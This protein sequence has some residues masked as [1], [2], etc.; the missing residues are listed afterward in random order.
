MVKSNAETV[1]Q[2]LEELPDNQKAVAEE[3]REFIL[4]HL[5]D[6]YQEAMNWGAIT[7]QV[8]LERYPDT[9]NK[10]PLS[11]ITLAAQKNHF[12]LY[13]MGVY[14]NPALKKKLAKGYEKTGKKLDMG[15]SC[16]RFK[17][18]EELPLDTLAEVISSLTPDQFIQSYEESRNRSRQ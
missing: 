8:P 16:L 14:Q 13:L 5:P 10:M 11:Y 15:K 3:V 7:Y 17:S 12:A 1:S 6:G 2:Y 4:E 18:V 9:Y